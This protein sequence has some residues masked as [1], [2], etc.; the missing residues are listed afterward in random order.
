[1][2]PTQAIIDS[3][4]FR[5]CI[6]STRLQVVL[7]PFLLSVFL[8]HCAAQGPVAIENILVSNRGIIVPLGRSV[9]LS[10]DDLQIQVTPGDRCVVTVLDNDPLAQRP[11]RLMPANFPCSFGPQDVV[12]SHFGARN[13]K[14]DV[15][16]LQIRYDS[17]SETILIPLTVSVEVS[18][19]Q[20]EILT[21]NLPIEVE[22]LMGISSAIDQSN[23]EFEYDR[24]EEQCKISV[25]SPISGLPRYGQLMNDTEALQM[26]DCDQFLRMGVRYQHTAATDSPNKDYLP[27]VVEIIDRD[28][29]ITKKEHFQILVRILEG[30]EN[31]PPSPEFSAKLNMEVNQFVMTA[32]TPDVLAAEDV[33]TPLDL[34]IF[35]ITKPLRP[36]EGHFVSTDDRNQVITSFYQRDVRDLKIAYKP[37]SQDADVRRVYFVE[38]EVIDSDGA[39]SD[40]FMLMIVVKPMNTL[41]PVVTTNTGIQLFEGQSRSLRAD[42]NL[43]VSDEDN[44]EDVKIFVADGVRHGQLLIPDGRKF[45][46]PEDLRTGAVIYQ[47]DDSESYSD[48]IIFRM[49]DEDNE[50]EFLFPIWVFPQDDKPPI[51]KVNTVLEISKNELK[52]ITTSVLSASDIDSEDSL[53]RFVLE[54]PYSEEGVV[55]MRQL[56]P[57][58]KE[59][60]DNWQFT[61]GVY[62]KVVDE[63]TQQDLIDGKIYYAHVGPHR[64]DFV[65]DRIFF[66]L[67]DSSDPPNVSDLKTFEVKI[68]PVDDQL[69]YLYPNTTLRMEVTEFQITEFR[70]RIMRFTDDDTDDREILYTVTS[71]PFDTDSNTPMESGYITLC[72]DP[73]TSI[74]T[75][76]QA[77]VNHRKICYHPPTEELGVIPRIIQFVYDVQDTN[78]NVLN[79][80]RFTILLRPM[81]NQPP[82]VK[83][84]GVRV[85]EGS[86]T[87]LST[88]ILDVEDPDTDKDSL[89]FVVMEVP[90]HGKIKMMDEVL[91]VGDFFTRNDIVDGVIVYSN[92]GGDQEVDNDH[93]MI[94]ISDGI[95]HVPVK[96]NVN[97]RSVEDER[98]AL[99]G[100]RSEI[101]KVVLE[102]QENSM[103]P[104]TADDIRITDA[105]SNDM[106]LVFTVEREPFEGIILRVPDQV[107]EFTQADIAAGLI[108]YQHTGGEVGIKG[109]ED[110][111][112]LSLVDPNKE[113]IVAGSLIDK[114]LVEVKIIPFD[115][116]PPIVT[117]DAPFEVLE[118][119]KAP[120][121]R[122]HLGATDIDTEDTDI[123][124]LVVG[125]P[126]SGYLEN[127]SP[128]PGSEKSRVGIPVSSFTIGD[129]RSEYINYVQSVHKGTEPRSDAFMFHC[130]DGLNKSP[131][132]RFDV[133]IYPGNDEVP[134]ISLRDFIVV[135]GG[136]L[137]IDLPIMNVVDLDDPADR[138][139]FVITEQ[140]KHGKIVR[141]TPEGSLRIQNFTLDDISGQSTI[142][143]EHDDSETTEDGF[144]F[145]LTDGA[146]NISRTV[147]IKVFPLDDETPRLTI[148][149]G[150][151]IDT[152]GDT[153]TITNKMLKA[154]DLDSSDPDLIYFVRQKPK[155]GYLRML[156]GDTVSNLTQGG[157]FT[158]R[159]IDERRIEYV[160]TGIG[161]VR[162]LIKFDITDSLNS[163]IDRYFYVTIEGLDMMFPKVINKGVELPEGGMVVLTTDLLSGTDL[164]TPDETLTFTVTR[165]PGR[166]HLE[167]SDSPGVPI[168]TFTQLQLAG[169]KIRYVHDLADEMKM[170][171]FEFEVTDGFNPVT[172]T[173]R[174]SLSDVDNRKPVLMFQNLR[175]Q[176][177]G[178]KL[179]TPFELKAEDSDTAPERIMFTVT[180]VPLHGILLFNISRTVTVFSQAD[181]NGNMI[182]YRHDGSE[183][184]EDSFSFTVTDGTHMD[185][186]V[187]PDTETTTRRPQTVKI[188][189]LPVD[190][191]IP[192]ININRGASYL[193]E[194]P[195]SRLGF[196]ISSRVL[197]TQDRDSPDD[198]LVYSVTRQPRWGYLINSA[199]GNR[200]I[201]NWTQVY[202]K[203]ISG[204][205]ASSAQ[206]ASDACGGTRTHDMVDTLS[207][208][209][210]TRWKTE[211][212]S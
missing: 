206:G 185:F 91:D 150:L 152:A 125:Q 193:S 77:Q 51:L 31:V 100:A 153:K 20:L 57:P 166:G 167:S 112:E 149:N 201:A 179:I 17:F 119:K 144:A 172:R 200:S 199:I 117:V 175:L 186:F 34:L 33:E 87:V 205:Q 58:P 168:S 32:I 94:D 53:I 110:F 2:S 209:P 4:P 151:Q 27:M 96:F 198:S 35:N 131:D 66:R 120:I 139:M 30:K 163:L 204:F 160:H 196:R 25:L 11:G 41:A 114:I 89:M 141:Q 173:F 103:V 5:T 8:S 1:M 194:L 174:I 115:N 71:P 83:N 68:A 195:G 184:Q 65:L 80:Q 181:L 38:M 86:F 62:E 164:N 113:I 182:S 85:L 3:R 79:N 107:N 169:N 138:I 177:G 192:Q 191:G 29:Q 9:Y 15:I 159:D 104:L 154:D 82:E 116:E 78:G 176:E 102:V 121:L 211:M 45:F 156:V 132:F 188:Y 36:H 37:P 212:I 14:Y 43:R 46:T 88:D 183:T 127:I 54:P 105:D 22:R 49:N 47:H 12:Y 137:R 118:S 109:R 145:Y 16:R 10:P 165:A 187:W 171:S 42:T 39:S 189:I 24:Q 61:E 93:F 92:D 75:F 158:Q 111:F 207:T 52:E 19:K 70:R 123:A 6:L 98:T 97:V 90:E 7:V 146:H 48:N 23:L 126:M 28:G 190:N 136:N 170:D 56:Q 157:N 124:C 76:T 162:D 106:Q 129:V 133:Q 59:D 21:R 135:E 122:R 74:S 210:S 134:E 44:L 101:L 155:Y 178:N 108:M 60:A 161:G 202:I 130:S 142:E 147:P 197:S 67:M 40:P 148:N 63:F 26:V 64:S 140:P 55:L 99:V 95:H 69:P 180:Q 128:A 143:Y 13:P 18:F 72:E 208:V 50:V 203:V 73:M 81:D 84:G